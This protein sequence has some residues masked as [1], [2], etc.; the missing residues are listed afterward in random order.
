VKKITP[1]RQV[2]K[3]EENNREESSDTDTELR[4]FFRG[5]YRHRVSAIG[6]NKEIASSPRSSQ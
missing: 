2:H 5:R 1:S 6:I 3:E 4:D